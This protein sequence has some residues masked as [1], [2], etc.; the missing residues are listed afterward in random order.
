MVPMVE[1]VS[2]AR[3]L[4]DNPA[5][6]A[7]Y[8]RTRRRFLVSTYLTKVLVVPAIIMAVFVTSL[9]RWSGV[10]AFAAAAVISERF[11]NQI[12]NVILR[13]DWF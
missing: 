2:M 7:V 5:R 11:G 10:V 9:L 12:E 1:A 8:N 3:R 4:F 13:D 6:Q